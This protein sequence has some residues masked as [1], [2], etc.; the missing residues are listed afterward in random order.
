[1]NVVTFA[2]YISPKILGTFGRGSAGLCVSQNEQ[3]YRSDDERWGERIVQHY[4][5][6]RIHGKLDDSP[7][8]QWSK[9]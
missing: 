8:V 7:R 3:I 2:P 6:N 5:S 1:M 9:E 4:M